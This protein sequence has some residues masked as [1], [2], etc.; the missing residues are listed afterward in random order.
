MSAVYQV[1]R[2]EPLPVSN[3]K[4][5]FH[6]GL[7]D[8]NGDDQ[9]D[10]DEYSHYMRSISATINGRETA[11]GKQVKLG[12]T[13]ADLMEVKRAMQNGESIWYVDS[14]E[15]SGSK[16][17]LHLLVFCTRQQTLANRLSQG[18][19]RHAF[20]RPSNATQGVLHRASLLE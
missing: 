17:P 6:G 12:E 20:R 4:V 18:C 13:S 9:D 1:K 7:S 14:T 2:F 16:A 5:V 3:I 11:S 8:N 10:H 19:L 15:M